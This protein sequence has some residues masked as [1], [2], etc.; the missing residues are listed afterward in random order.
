MNIFTNGVES[1]QLVRRKGVKK[2][3]I[4]GRSRGLEWVFLGLRVEVTGF[5]KQECGPS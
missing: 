4:Q 2:W 1:S 3:D 5:L